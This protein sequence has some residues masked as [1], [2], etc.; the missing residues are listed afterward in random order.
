MS[1]STTLPPHPH[2]Q[3]Y[4]RE[5]LEMEEDQNEP[6][7]ETTGSTE[8]TNNNNNGATVASAS[9]EAARLVRISSTGSVIGPGLDDGM[10]PALPHAGQDTRA[11]SLPPHIRIDT[12]GTEHDRRDD[13]DEDEDDD[14]ITLK[15]RPIHEDTS[16]PDEDELK[17][18]DRSGEKSALDH[19]HWE[20]VTFFDLHDPEHQPGD[21]GRIDWTIENYNGTKD[22]P[23]KELLMRSP[24]VRVGGHDWQIKFYP[25]GNDSEYLSIYVECVS[26]VS[27][28]GRDDKPARN[29][30]HLVEAAAGED[31]KRVDR[32]ELLGDERNTIHSMK[33]IP[34]PIVQPS[35]AKPVRGRSSVA[36]QVSV[37]LYN[38]NEPR[39]NYFKTGA[40]RFCPKSPDWGWTRFH[41][42]YYEIHHRHYRQ[43]QALLRNDKLAFRCYIRVTNDTTGCLWEHPSRD[44]PWDSF[45]MTG[46]QGLSA[47]VSRPLPGG[48][49]VSAVSSWMLFR[50]FRELLYDI[51]V[52]GPGTETRSRPKPVIQALQRVLFE[53]RARYQPGNGPVDLESLRDALRWYG[54]GDSIDDMDVIETWETLRTK[55]GHEVVGTNF[56]ERLS[57]LF[58]EIKDRRLG[59][60]HYRISVENY[61]SI[62]AAV[63][64]T[65]GL[66]PSKFS[67][68][69]KAGGHP[70]LLSI[71]LERQKFDTN[72]RTWKRL[73]KRMKLDETI[74]VDGVYYTLYGFIAHRGGLQSNLYHSVLRPGG[75][76]GKWYTYQDGKE[77][78]HVVCLTR[79][80]AI[81]AHEGSSVAKE[82]TPLAYV[83][84]YIRNDVL[85]SVPEAEH[86]WD[87]SQWIAKEGTTSC[88]P[89][90]FLA[91][92]SVAPPIT[93]EAH[94]AGVVSR[95][96]A[97]D[98]TEDNST[99]GCVS[100]RVRE[101]IATVT[102]RVFDSR[103]VL[104]HDGPGVLDI[105]GI[106][107]SSERYVYNLS[108]DANATAKDI[109]MRLA[110]I[111]EGVKD[112]KQCRLWVL[113]S[114]HGTLACPTILHL[115]LDD[116][117]LSVGG[118]WTLKDVRERCPEYRLLLHVFDLKDMKGPVLTHSSTLTS[119]QTMHNA[120][121]WAFP[122]SVHGQASNDQA[123]DASEA[124]ALRHGVAWAEDT[125]MSGSGEDD[126]TAPVVLEV[127][128][129]GSYIPHGSRN[130]ETNAFVDLNASLP[131]M[132]AYLMDRTAVVAVD[133]VP[134]GAPTVHWPLPP[135]I[136][137]DDFGNIY[138]IL[139]TFDAE[140]QT[141]KSHGGYSANL[142]D[143]VDT[144]TSEILDTLR[145][146]EL[147][148][149]DK[150][151]A[152]YAIRSNRRFNQED[153][154]GSQTPIVIAQFSVSDAVREAVTARGDFVDVNEYLKYRCDLMNHPSTLNGFF[155]LDYFSD[156]YYQGNLW[157]GF[158]HGHGTHIGFNN[159]SYT[160]TFVMNH[161]H[162]QGRMTFANGDVYDGAWVNGLQHGHG[163]F[164]EAKT[165]NVY[166]GGWKEGKKHG[167]GVTQWKVAADQQ[168][169]CQMCYEGEMEAAFYDCGHVCACLAC[170]RRVEQCPVCRKRVLAAVK[171]YFV[172]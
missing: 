172:T 158:R 58:G 77:G 153:F 136:F 67:S 104:Q 85:D 139:K 59:V 88:N 90:G 54:I 143:R 48:N 110:S 6:E 20:K 16:G 22:H 107:W 137:D 154:G 150:L 82:S 84:M 169:C 38:P 157:K 37:V 31:E 51:R 159:D 166:T 24:T 44:N 86:V 79:K 147:F 121:S 83:V 124:T 14:D 109:R 30:D 144:T 94:E 122:N 167:E 32:S 101:D 164:T 102:V 96:V 141:L 138:F 87:G 35:G 134:N 133:A 75:R 123:A 52:P 78:N 55:I 98:M 64:A 29:G 5:D 125:P 108:M 116:P 66:V 28:K 27:E 17:Y 41:V 91:T 42:S 81:R 40:H 33:N 115:S 68:K 2:G 50:P 73:L 148:R 140:N 155:T 128:S 7:Q 39:V 76:E 142:D 165:G 130:A 34:L 117:K 162:G 63:T 1:T 161:R 15:W 19:A 168:K 12:P 145:P 21:S 151:S 97:K 135:Q 80:E 47:S 71:E 57:I 8:P 149:E 119:V 36:A 25:R 152:C 99:T 62:Q 93:A 23:N 100:N 61:S 132:P 118:T 26:L 49:L 171:L 60:P 95:N 126:E 170:A 9:S 89:V 114:A 111:V 45:A 18:L 65:R 46:L 11:L 56:E 163:T 156:E 10:T 103:L 112:P 3:N 92:C 105:F 4:D 72:T 106:N 53:M 129:N 113:D 131:A 160:G 43:R 127:A 120:A 70:Y 146:F 74:I 13:S 69:T